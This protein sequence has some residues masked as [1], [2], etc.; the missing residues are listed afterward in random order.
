MSVANDGNIFVN[1]G[2][3]AS[4]LCEII[5]GD[6]SLDTGMTMSGLMSLSNF[7]FGAVRSAYS[8]KFKCRDGE[9]TYN[10]S[11]SSWVQTPYD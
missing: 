9:I 1:V 7:P 10:A 5:L 8:P 3:N 11:T 6:P 2:G 4:N